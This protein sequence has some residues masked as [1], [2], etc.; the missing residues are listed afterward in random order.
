[1]KKLAKEA[2]EEIREAIVAADDCFVLTRDGHRI[3]DEGVWRIESIID[4]KL[5]PVMDELKKARGLTMIDSVLALGHI[6]LALAKLSEEE[7]TPPNS[8]QGAL[9]S[10]P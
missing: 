9:D 3:T 5:D 1:M 2:A 8:L 7:T 4:A 10:R 6:N